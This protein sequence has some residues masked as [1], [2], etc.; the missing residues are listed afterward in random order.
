MKPIENKL[1]LY[2]TEML[3]AG[4]FPILSIYHKKESEKKGYYNKID[5]AFI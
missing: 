3:L 5:N 4:D 1:S 2:G